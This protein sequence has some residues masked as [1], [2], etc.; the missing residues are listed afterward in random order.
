[1]ALPPYQETKARHSD[2]RRLRTRVQRDTLLC[3]RI[4]WVQG[5]SFRVYG[6]RKESR[7][8]RHA[9]ACV[10]PLTAER[11]MEPMNLRGVVPSSCCGT[12]LRL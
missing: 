2:P 8:R 7:Q 9:D 5:K 10:E 11:L 4:Q 3:V 12:T 6:A 1:M